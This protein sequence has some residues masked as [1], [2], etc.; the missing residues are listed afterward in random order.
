MRYFNIVIR[1]VGKNA[2]QFDASALYIQCTMRM[3][4]IIPVRKRNIENK[5]KIVKYMKKNLKKYLLKMLK[6]RIKDITNMLF[7]KNSLFN[8]LYYETLLFN[9]KLLCDICYAF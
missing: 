5:Q 7:S 4:K 2:I 8:E 3:R 1:T 9:I 6:Q